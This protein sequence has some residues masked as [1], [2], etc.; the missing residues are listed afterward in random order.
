MTETEFLKELINLIKLNRQQKRLTFKELSEKTG[1]STKY[2][3]S[4]ELGKHDPS[5]SNYFRIIKVLEIPIESLY[6][7]IYTHLNE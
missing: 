5:I 4:L 7:I 2:L 3:N 6:K 1:L